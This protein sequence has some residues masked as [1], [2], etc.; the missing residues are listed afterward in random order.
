MHSLVSVL[1]FGTGKRLPPRR[2]AAF[3]EAKY[4]LGTLYASCDFPIKDR[5]LFTD[6]PQHRQRSLVLDTTCPA[7]LPYPFSTSS[8]HLHRSIHSRH[9]SRRVC[10]RPMPT[11]LLS[12]FQRSTRKTL[13]TGKE[14]TPTGD[15]DHAIR[16]HRA[17][18]EERQG[19]AG[20]AKEEGQSGEGAGAGDRS[21]E[22]DGD[23]GQREGGEEGQ[24]MWRFDHFE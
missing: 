22:E 17:D 10:R 9:L 23:A 2:Q 15:H 13:H 8:A 14:Q 11:V 24:S 16:R 19:R 1:L 12:P 4:A 6:F 7:S 20:I 5:L 21:R 3:T 18:E